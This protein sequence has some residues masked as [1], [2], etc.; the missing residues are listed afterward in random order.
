[1]TVARFASTS[2]LVGATSTRVVTSFGDDTFAG[3]DIPFAFNFGSTN[4]G[5]N[6]NGGVWVGSNGY[7][8]FGG[9]SSQYSGLGA[10]NP[11]LRAIH[12]GSTDSSW[13]ALYVDNQSAAQGRLRIRWEGFAG[14]QETLDTVIWEASFWVNGSVTLCVGPTNALVGQVSAVSGVSNGAGAWLATYTLALNSLYVISGLGVPPP[15]PPPVVSV[16]ITSAPSTTCLGGATGMA[17]LVTSFEDDGI[18]Q[19]PAMPYTFLFGGVNHGS[20]VFAASNGYIL[21]GGS[22]LAWENLGPANPPFKSLHIGSKEASW[23]GLW[24]QNEGTGASRRLRI[25]YEG[26]SSY[27]QL[28]APNV[29]WEA[30]FWENNTLSVCVGA[31]ALAGAAG[32]QSGVG[33]GAGR[34]L[35]SYQ[36]AANTQYV[37]SG[38]A[39]YNAAARMP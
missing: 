39:N 33:D 37:I 31:N 15:S 7:I 14:Y 10:S 32:V 24:A 36:L 38:L 6:A 18:T 8:T 23:R 12:V 29:V 16:A 21:F 9:S 20:S 1:V 5:N 30:S 13:N 3:V 27:K 22:S 17:A 35:A 4:Y 28:A 11:A 25:R 34:W 26:F 19:L 2:C